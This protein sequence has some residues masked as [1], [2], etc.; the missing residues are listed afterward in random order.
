MST[1]ELIDE[2]T[3]RRFLTLLHERAASALSGVRRPGLLQLVSISPDDRGMSYSPFAIGDI[4]HMLK[5]VLADAKAGRNVYIET[6]T[7]RPG[8]PKER[9]PGRGKAD[10]TIGLFAFVIDSDA[11]KGQAGHIDHINGDATIIETSPGNR[12]I[13]LFLHRALSAADAEP[14]GAMIRKAVGADHNTGVITQPYRV[15]GTP[16]Y[17]DARKRARGRT[18]VATKLIATSDRL[19]VSTEIKAVFSTSGAQVAKTQPRRNKRDG[20]GH[21]TPRR[22]AIAKAKVAAKVKSQT[23]RSAA[24]YGAVC[25]C[26]DA[27][28]TPDE[29]EV[30]MREHPDGPQQKYL[31]GGDRLRQEIDRSF[32]KIEQ[33]Q[34]QR[35]EEHAQHVEAGKGIDGAELLD[36]IYE[37]LSRFVVYPS[38][39]AHVAHVLWIA[40]TH[41]MDCWD[42]TPRLTFLSPEPGSGKS[43]ALELTET[44]A[45]APIL[46]ANVTP[47]YLFRRAAQEQVTLLV[48]E[49]DT[50]FSVKSEG[51]EKIRAFLNASHRRGNSAGHCIGQG[52]NIT[53]EDSPCFVAVAL[54]ALALSHMPETVMSRS[55]I[56][57]MRRQPNQFRRI[58]VAGMSRKA[59]HCVIVSPYGQLPSLTISSDGSTAM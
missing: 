38:K 43:R 1:Q 44:L 22:K 36:R 23:D 30:E 29:V 9:R 11:D 58:A 42:S 24:F 32:E 46:V 20:L 14:L 45:P 40:H 8:R 3:V 18:V 57:H 27:G 28:M 12:H 16:N 19:W 35:D 59:M 15:P 13:W 39:E 53:P 10:A 56:I 52:T 33:Q 4:D 34:Q 47:A 49:A 50:V 51:S 55:I 26:A 31:E 2:P 25:A 37:F 54:A 6:R 41:L 48:D 21:S 5:A 17:P 7:V